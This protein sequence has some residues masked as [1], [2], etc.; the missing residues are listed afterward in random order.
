MRA[1]AVLPLLSPDVRTL[2]AYG[3]G[4][5]HLRDR[6]GERR[7]LA[8]PRGASGSPLGPGERVGSLER[9][10]TWTLTFRAGGHAPT[11]CRPRSER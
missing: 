7:L 2:A 8:W 6:E 9:H 11:A 4:V 10:R 3:R 5:V 1:G